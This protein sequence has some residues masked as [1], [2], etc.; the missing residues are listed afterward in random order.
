MQSRKGKRKPL[1]SS[2]ESDNATEEGA[3]DSAANRKRAGDKER[4]ESNRET[5]GRGD[6]FPS[7]DEEVALLIN[8]RLFVSYSLF[9]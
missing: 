7:F 8:Y 5:R 3:Q 6:L 4:T 9:C 1:F 2:K